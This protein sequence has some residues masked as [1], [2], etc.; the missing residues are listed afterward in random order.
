MEVVCVFVDTE[1]SSRSRSPVCFVCFF[2]LL[3]CLYVCARELN[4][5]ATH[6]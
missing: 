6:G 2:N 1:V 4:I 5:L 3:V